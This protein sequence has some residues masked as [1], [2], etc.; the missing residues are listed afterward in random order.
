MLHSAYI[1]KKNPPAYLLLLTLQ[2]ALQW[3]YSPS[4][5]LRCSLIAARAAKNHISLRRPKHYAG[6]DLLCWTRLDKCHMRTV[7][8][9]QLACSCLLVNGNITLFM[10][11]KTLYK[12]ECAGPVTQCISIF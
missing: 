9:E 2:E 11:C 5:V 7:T 12:S 1:V 6:T 4:P 10:L 3:N 8:K